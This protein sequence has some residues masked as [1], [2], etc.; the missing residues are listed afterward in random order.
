MQKLN[1][2]FPKKTS[3]TEKEDENESCPFQSKIFW[4]KFHYYFYKRLKKMTFWGNILVCIFSRLCLSK[5]SKICVIGK[6]LDFRTIF[7]QNG[8]RFYLI[9]LAR[10]TV[11]SFNGQVETENISKPRIWKEIRKKFMFWSVRLKLELKLV[12]YLFRI[13]SNKRRS[14]SKLLENLVFS[15]LAL[16][17]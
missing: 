6:S 3:G 9:T 17:P 15:N 1:L 10:S 16:I 2:T 14:K 4:K 13:S 12:L 8:D 11:V 7:S 5:L